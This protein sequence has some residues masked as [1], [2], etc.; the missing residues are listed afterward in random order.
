MLTL[1]QKELIHSKLPFRYRH[2]WI[3]RTILGVSIGMALT[4][5]LSAMYVASVIKDVPKVEKHA[6]MS[7]ASSRMV[8]KDGNQIWS[9]AKNQREYVKDQDIPELYKKL[10]L[11]T[12]DQSFYTHRGFNP[13][14][15]LNAGLSAIKEKLGGSR[16][17]GGSGIEQQLIKLSVFSTS[18]KDRTLNRKIKELF[19]AQQLDENYDKA[20]ILEYYINK[21]YMGEDSYGAQT[22]A[23]T[24]F[25]KPLTQCSLSQLA[26]I[27][28]LGK[29]PSEYNLYDNK[30]SCQNRR[31]TVLKLAVDHHLITQE[32]YDQAI[33][34]PIDKDLQPRHWQ[35]KEVNDSVLTHNAFVMSTLNQVKAL[36]YNLDQ[37]PLEIHTTLDAK[38][39]KEVK[40]FVDSN[41]KYFTRSDTQMAF[42]A[43]EPSTGHVVA[44]LGGRHESE[45]YGLNRAT[46]TVRS[47]GSSIKPLIIAGVI[48]QLNLPTSSPISSAPYQYPGTNVVAH[49]YGGY[50]WGTLPMFDALANSL[51][52]PMLRYFAQAGGPTLQA[53]LTR[54]GF[55]FDHD[56]LQSEVI[57]L[58]ASTE[59]MASAMGTLSNQGIYK[60]PQYITKLVF[61]DQS[62]KSITFDDVNAVAPGTAYSVLSIMRYIVEDDK[63]LHHRAKI[64]KVTQALK[65]GTTAMDSA[66][67]YP[68]DAVTDLWMAGTTK[69]VAG[70]LWIG[71]DNPRPDDGSYMKEDPQTEY[72]DRLYRDLM[73]IVSKGRDGS[74]WEVP[75]DHVRSVGGSGWHTYYQSLDKGHQAKAYPAPLNPQLTG[76]AVNILLDPTIMKQ[77][78]TI[79]E[80]LIPDVPKDYQEGSWKDAIK[81]QEDQLKKDEDRYKKDKK[82]GGNGE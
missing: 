17:R 15:V 81:Q 56:L 5:S 35:N 32:D 13:K 60:K 57:G 72:K 69:G 45:P 20:T 10:L 40:D 46:Q 53:T 4:A 18:E 79:D 50:N 54:L 52:T 55:T 2:P 78:A 67:G 77:K 68:K 3:T 28:G 12:E 16:A 21:I 49:N 80:S 23:K 6:L 44:Q 31:D 65:S 24:Y 42:T 1:R 70:A 76:D 11:I 74:D 38:L 25:N 82:E 22:I 33:N 8:D 27:A 64:P 19:L 47:T 30:K 75:T 29:A 73:A 7:D 61:S 36:G 62:E 14:G 34:T 51:N 58:N 59:Q 26:F 37:T 43:V 48:E 39:N 71:L 41:D 63:G 66:L 9:S